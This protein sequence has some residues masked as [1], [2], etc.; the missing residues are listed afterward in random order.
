MF[1]IPCLTSYIKLILT[2]SYVALNDVVR[3]VRDGFLLQIFLR[4]SHSLGLLYS[5][6]HT[7]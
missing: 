6:N 7:G 1:Q 3:N 5:Y 2:K 4:I